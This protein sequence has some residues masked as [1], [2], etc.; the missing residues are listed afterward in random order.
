MRMPTVKTLQSIPDAD[1]KRMREILKMTRTE[2]LCIPV[3]EARDSEC[4]HPPK[5]WDLRMA[6]LNEAARTFGYESC[7]SENREY[8]EYL[9]T[10]D[11]YVPTIIY[12][13]GRY[14]VQSVGDFIETMERQGVHF[15]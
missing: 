9:N 7:E 12:W 3:C 8:A 10:G 4:Y 15:K 6:A 1:H 14:R 13:R 5:T 11:S 2:L